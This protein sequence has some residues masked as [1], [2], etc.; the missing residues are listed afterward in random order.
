MCATPVW[1]RS[2]WITECTCSA[3]TLIGWLSHRQSSV[4]PVTHKIPSQSTFCRAYYLYS[5]SK[6]RVV[7]LQSSFD[8]FGFWSRL[9]HNNNY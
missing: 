9:R 1:T 6:L 5:L 2:F 3:V 7:T 4:C 8:T